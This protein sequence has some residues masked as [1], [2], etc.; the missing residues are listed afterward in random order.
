MQDFSVFRVDA[1]FSASLREVRPFVERHIDALLDDFYDEIRRMPALMTLFGSET[2][3]SG[4]R[5]AQR[6][7]WLDVLFVGDW[8]K[9]RVHSRKVALVHLER[10]I[11]PD[12]YQAAY[13]RVL[14][15]LAGALGKRVGRRGEPW[16]RTIDTIIRAVFIDMRAVLDVYL[17]EEAARHRMATKAHADSFE[18]TI[19]TTTEGFT[20][21]IDSLN[22]ILSETH[23]GATHLA[24]QAR[25]LGRASRGA[26]EAVRVVAAA[27]E[28]MSAAVHRIGDRNGEAARVAG[29][30]ARQAMEMDEIIAA[31]REAGTGIDSAVALIGAIASQTNLLAL[32]ASIEA[33]RA[34]A[35][36]K[37][38]AVVANEVK[39]LANQTAA[40][41]GDV[42]G[43]VKEIQAA[44]DRATQAIGRFTDTVKSLE[45]LSIEVSDAIRDQEDAVSDMTRGLRAAADHVRDLDSACAQVDDVAQT[46]ASAVGQA[47]DSIR[48]L[49]SRSRSLRDTSQAFLQ[50]VRAVG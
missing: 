46:S 33:A 47:E 40:G 10:G 50:E 9:H 3:L 11:T 21:D 7:Y 44:V 13:A 6:R 37:G 24:E 12:V 1:A 48:E 49:G 45:T 27:S 17:H 8:E 15:G 18:R 30:A 20:R 22:R 2:A 32:N 43:R 19:L 4:A 36:G 31:L 35:A 26:S 14:S 28:N 39:A 38:F 23:E 42:S 5:A 16:E 29:T 25:G 34:G 41:T